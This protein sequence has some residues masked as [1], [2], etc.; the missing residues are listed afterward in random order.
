MESW[1]PGARIRLARQQRG[2]TQAALAA[3]VGVTQAAVSSWEAGAETPS[4]THTLKL[5]LVLPELRSDLPRD[6][7]D[8]LVRVERALFADRCTC[9]DCSCHVPDTATDLVA[10]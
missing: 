3:A 9:E 4:F 1:A 2:L 5:L 10:R 6:L 8:L 7:V